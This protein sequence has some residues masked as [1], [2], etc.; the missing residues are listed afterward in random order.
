MAVMQVM[1]E[2]IATVRLLE[3]VRS[4]PASSIST[5]ASVPSWAGLMVETGCSGG[6]GG[7]GEEGMVASVTA[8][9]AF[10]CENVGTWCLEHG[11]MVF[12]TFHSW[13]DA[14]LPSHSWS[15]A[16]HLSNRTVNPANSH[17]SSMLNRPNAMSLHSS[18]VVL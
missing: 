7:K 14:T 8:G 1:Q 9:T 6:E 15:Y 13:L 2:M 10:G 12:L 18:D 11:L 5:V 16:E 4:G 17:V 3:T